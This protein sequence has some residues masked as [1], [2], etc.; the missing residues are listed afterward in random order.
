MPAGIR[1]GVHGADVGVEEV[2][3]QIQVEHACT[4]SLCSDGCHLNVKAARAQG[5]VLGVAIG[6]GVQISKLSDDGSYSRN[7]FSG[8]GRNLSSINRVMEAVAAT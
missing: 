8:V 6:C 1:T 2:G 4:T 7:S 3:L 5:T